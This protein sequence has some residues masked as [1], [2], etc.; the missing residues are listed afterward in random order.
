MIPLLLGSLLTIA[1]IGYIYYAYQKV[2]YWERKGI[3]SLKAPIFTG[4]LTAIADPKVPWS[5]S[6]RKYTKKFGN[7]WPIRR[8]AHELFVTRFEEFQKQKRF[9]LIETSAEDPSA[10]LGMTWGPR[11]KRLRSIVAPQFS[12]Q[13]LK[14]ILP[15]IRDSANHLVD[16]IS[17]NGEGKGFEIQ[18]YFQ[19]YTMDIIARV[20]MG[21]QGSKQ[22]ETDL[23]PIMKT[24][25][26]RDP[27]DPIFYW[28][29]AMPVFGKYIRMGFFLVM[30]LVKNSFM[31]AVSLIENAVKERKEQRANGASSND[32]E[33]AD[34]IDLF[35]DAEEEIDFSEEKKQNFKNMHV[36][37]HLHEREVIM[38]LLMFLIVGFDTT[39][40][41]LAY[42][43]WYLAKYPKIL[44]K[45]QEEIE[46]VCG[47]EE[48]TYDNLNEL[49]YMD[50]VIKE[51]LRLNPLGVFVSSRVAAHRCEFAGVQLEEGDSVQIDVFSIQY[52]K[53]IWGDDVEEFNPDRFLNLTADQKEAYL[54]FGAGPRQCVGMRLA[55]LEQRMAFAALLRKYDIVA[56]PETEKE[57]Q[58]QGWTTMSPKSVT[59]QIRKRGME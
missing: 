46:Q 31:R 42:V 53:E 52:S 9:P 59:V 17:K 56:G 37:R 14:K 15:T 50:C 38:Q 1:I 28:A 45:L 4:S 43:S 18:R 7:W 21:Q 41:S 5:A 3:P 29:S 6:L 24:F 22:F 25:F 35:L 27:R 11:W 54:A 51:A 44:K 49:K 58:L 19:E 34:Y 55:Y 40:N 48:L 2:S 8:K 33:V 16:H 32:K 12:N 30:S 26:D 36:K 10:H 13:S 20:S 39:S 23:V 47:D 57:L